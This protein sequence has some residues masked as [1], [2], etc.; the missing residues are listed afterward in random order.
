MV[1]VTKDDV[2]AAAERI[3]GRVFRGYRPTVA[4][5]LVHVSHFTPQ[6][7]RMALEQAGFAEIDIRPAAPVLPP[8]AA[9]PRR[10]ARV[11]FLR[12]TTIAARALPF[13]ARSPL[14]MNLQAYARS[15]GAER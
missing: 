12:G 11:A 1:P 13:G 9:G 2:L 4:D 7:L 8:E 15:G 14:A 10:A 3:R 6:S 5:N